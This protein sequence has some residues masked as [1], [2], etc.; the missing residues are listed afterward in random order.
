MAQK[1]AAGFMSRARVLA[2]G[3]SRHVRKAP[4]LAACLL[5]G[6]GVP[7]RAADAVRGEATFSAGG[8]FARL[9]I[10]LGEDVPS[11]VTTAGSILIIRF[12]RAVDVPVDRVPEGAP[13]YVNSARRDP[14][15]SA[16]RLSLARRVTVNTMNAGE[17]TFIDLLPEGWKGPPPSLPMDVVKELAERARVA[18][19]ALRAQRATAETKKRP[20]IRVRASVQPTFVRFVFEMPDGVGVS[21]VLNEQKLT[22]AFNAG[23]NFDLADAVVAAPPNV[24][25]IKQK[26]DIDQTSVEIALIG[27][28]DVHSFRDEKNYV[29]DISF[30]PD[31]GKTAATAEAV[32]AQARPVAQSHGPAPEKPTAEKPKEA[33]REIAPPTSETIA[34]EA[35]IEAKIEAKPE[36]KPEAPAAMPP[37]EAPKPTPAPAAEA[38][39]AAEPPKDVSKP[40][41]P[42]TEA[43]VAPVK[44]AVSEALKEVVKEAAKEPVKES[45]KA[46]SAE[47]P[48]APQPTVASVDVRR[49]SDGLRVIFP[50]QVAT[51]AAA[52]RRGDTVW[53]VFDTPK[54]IDVEAIRGRGGAMIGEVS[55]M[56]LDKGQAVRIRLTRPLV[57]SLTSEEVGKETNWLLTLADKIQATPLPL[58]MSR[59]ITDPAL[60]N[61]AIPFANPGLLHKLTDP[62]AGDT[63]YVVT[64]QRP[65]RGF[66]KRQD[67]VDLSLLESAHG[68]AIRPNSDE[69]GVEVGADKVIL[70]KKGGLTLSPV[71]I[72]AERAPTAVRPV[73]SPEG[74]RKGQSE[75]FWTRQGSLITAIAAVEPAQRSL[76]R[77]DLAQFYMSRAMYHEAKSVTDLML[78]DPLNKEESGALIMHAIANILIGRPAQGLKDLANPVIGNSHDS[79]LWKALAY[80]RQGK[81][82]D[83]RE[84]FKNVEF[85]I[86]SLPIDIQRIVTL[87]AMRASLEVKDYAG[88]SKRRSE[89]EVVGISPEAAPG[90]AVLRG[91]LAEALGHD[92][93]ALDDYKFAVASNDRQAAA[94]AKQLEVA[95]RQKRD[96]ISKEDAL[97]EL[98]TLSMTWRGD[99]IEVKTLQMLSQIYAENGRYRDAL[100]AARTATRLQPNAEASR[101]AQD[102][103]SDLF[104]Q[105]FL[106]PKGDE[107]P[108]VEALGMFY[109]FRELTPIGRRG[110]ELIRRLADRLAS[111]D[112]LDQAAELLQYQVDHRL[113]GAARAQVAARLAMIYLAN[114]KPDM[115]I[116]ALRASRIS[117]LSGELRQQRL[118]LE[119]RAQSD[120]GRHDLALD[121]VSNV[122]GREVLRLRSDI[123]WA[124]RRWR[125]SA[126]QIELYYGDRFRDFKPLN[127]VEKSDIIRA[128]V[129]YALADDSIGLSRFREKYAPLM[130]ESADRVAFDIASKPAASS[131]AEFAEIAKLAASVDTLDGFLREMKQRFPD[132]TARAPA[133]PQ[134]KDEADHTGSLPTIPVVRQIKMTR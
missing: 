67:L 108:P 19:R 24:A 87:E 46:A 64:G 35:K 125:E 21:S 54:P 65:V 56:P 93:D 39:H 118:L 107:L 85:A 8:G 10:K 36:V 124:A 42:A 33:H 89:I 34:R 126:E 105:I 129:G 101:Q 31:K 94:E 110:D 88:A 52:F 82:A 20:Q 120:V 131:S 133:S 17:R 27:D 109:E 112:L 121:I 74:W 50:L 95:L 134:A 100:R 29:V 58:M 78:A 130:S 26:S 3:L 83:A 41:A 122:S 18:E 43:V 127:A 70:G 63:L 5:I 99:S 62:D 128:A 28:S 25:S 49:D 12:D 80:A 116:S 114:R 11:E 2:R 73:F 37:V 71:D 81:W 22:L 92:K 119:A 123:F 51:P 76:P 13:D 45:V 115:A 44:P 40:A 30:Q 7:A 90:F 48:A 53:L 97:R 84:K 32:I 68:I 69:V 77:L 60:A 104:T 106:G 9:V 1:A 79:Q 86:A 117:D 47:A 113:E 15:G 111:I 98:E 91:R 38:P 59:N 16:I 103:A 66:I 57:Y 132:A 102:L 61:I 72:S 96:E 55:R 23:L 6:L 75:D 14:D 4:V